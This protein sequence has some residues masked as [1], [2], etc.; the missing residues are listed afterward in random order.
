M[1]LGL[2]DKPVLVLASSAGIGKAAARE[3][4]AEGARVM[5]F[6]RSEERL[7]GA[8]QDISAATGRQPRYTVGDITH[9]ADLRRAVGETVRHFGGIYALVNNC[10]GPPAGPFNNFDDA[11]WQNAFELTLLSYIRSIREV[12][13][14]MEKNGGGRI[15]NLTSSSTRQAIDGLILS[16][17]F[18][19]GVVGLT[20][21]LSRELAPANI[22]INVA[23]PGKVQTQRAAELLEIRARKSGKSTQELKKAA[24]AEVPLGRYGRPEEMARLVVFLSSQANTYITGQVVLAD[25]GLVRAY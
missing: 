1:D 14:I 18:R 15:V 8:Q 4:A 19:L 11:A 10:G 16:N 7:R 17:T 3:F 22:L 25:G 23:G 9:P 6:A 13:P 5:L 20:K 2:K 21:T 12:R 24:E